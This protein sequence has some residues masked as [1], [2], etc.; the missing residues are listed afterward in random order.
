[1]TIKK[2]F[3]CAIVLMIA[4]SVSAQSNTS[5]LPGKEVYKDNNVVF[6]Q[7]DKHTWVGTGHLMANKSL[8]LIE[9]KKKSILLDAGTKID[10]LDK[11]VK[12]ISSRPITLIAT[13][14]HPDHTGSAI[15][16][17]PEIYINAADT[18]NIPFCMP[19]YKG[20][21]KYLKD[22]EFI[23]LGDRKIEVV[24]TPGHTPGS[25]SFID[26]DNG[27]GFSGDSFGSGNLLLGMD[28]HTL[29]STCKKM[30][31][32]IQ[33]D[34]I[35]F[36]YP[37]HY[38]GTNVETPQRIKDMITLSNDVLTGKV[39]GKENPQGMMGLD[40]I[41]NDYGV[42]INYNEKQLKKSQDMKEVYDFLKKCG[43]YFLATVDK[44]Q[45]HVRPFGTIE[46]F[47]GKLYIQTGKSKK[48]AKQL[49]ENP[50]AEICAFDGKQ[51]L[52]V[53]T[54][55][56]EDCRI[57]AKRHMLDSYPELKSMYSADDP[58]TEVLYMKE[59]TATF[60]SF[61]ENPKTLKF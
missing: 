34:G 40:R 61:T 4:L 25:T 38:F 6:H 9:G 2:I 29:I 17:F 14:V 32:I 49:A 27:Y 45:P 26:K 55:L 10:N 24:F 39:E 13:H 59:T 60:Y 44:D 41:V 18:V 30:N 8:Y 53:E 1:M 47:E 19:N 57:E 12:R 36:L 43:H 11:I 23:D 48:V 7:I 52:R 37:G 33:K 42:R 16:Y 28:F 35:R 56:V 54:S 3:Y 5:Q 15:N 20:K 51:W 58:N 31:S 46:L 50:K 21:I 22:G